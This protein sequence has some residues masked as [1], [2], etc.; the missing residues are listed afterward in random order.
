MG[1]ALVP[2]M[3]AA[4]RDGVVMR[5]LGAER[6]VRHVVAAVRKGGESGRAVSRVLQ[7]LQDPAAASGHSGAN[8]Y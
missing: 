4:R 2:R 6:P 3:A 7:A 5:H 1:V 8:S